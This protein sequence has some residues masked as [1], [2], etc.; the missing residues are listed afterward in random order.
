LPIGRSG[1]NRWRL[2]DQTR[3]YGLRTL[4]AEDKL[5]ATSLEHFDLLEAV[6][7]GD[8]DRA[9]AEMERHLAHVRG[10]WADR[11]ARKPRISATGRLPGGPDPLPTS[12]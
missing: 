9:A 8:V 5:V 1:V 11:Q 7:S 10:D 3:L 6:L 12:D 2:R 4:A